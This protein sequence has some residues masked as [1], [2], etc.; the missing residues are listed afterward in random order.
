MSTIANAYRLAGLKSKYGDEFPRMVG[1]ILDEAGATAEENVPLLL[2]VG[3]ENLTLLGD[4]EQ[5]GPVIVNH[6]PCK[7]AVQRSLLE[8]LQASSVQCSLL[9]EQYRMPALLGDLVSRLSYHGKPGPGIM[10]DK[11][12][13]STLRRYLSEAPD[14]LPNERARK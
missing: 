3:V 6:G 4:Q 2:D 5:L 7:K 8:R 11:G 14:A 13:T 9:T 10:I 12:P 1:A